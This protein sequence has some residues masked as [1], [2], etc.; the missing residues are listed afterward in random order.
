M[1][2]YLSA[3]EVKQFDR[4]TT[5]RVITE[6]KPYDEA[7]KEFHRLIKSE[8]EDYSLLKAKKIAFKYNFS[9]QIVAD[10]IRPYK[11]KNYQLRLDTFWGAEEW[12]NKLNNT[13]P[14]DPNSK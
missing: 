1:I 13:D 6:N 8:H 11:A 9:D 14:T 7:L 12:K 4:L 2:I 10:A 3:K 5:P